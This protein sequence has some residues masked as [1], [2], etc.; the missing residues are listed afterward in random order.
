M[1]GYA[2]TEAID[3]WDGNWLRVSARAGASGTAVWATG[4]I[5]DTVS[6]LRFGRELTASCEVL[7][8][9]ATLKSHESNLV[10]QVTSLGQSGHLEVWA[11]LTPDHCAQGHRFDFAADPSYFSRVIA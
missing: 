9:D 5:L 7:S 1:H 11:E 6:V 3:A 4:V 10:V 8:G 2:H